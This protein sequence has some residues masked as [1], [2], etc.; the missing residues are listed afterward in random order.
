MRFVARLLG[1]LWALPNSFVAMILCAAASPWGIHARI[2]TGVL[3]VHGRGI[4][5]ALKAVPITGGAIAITLG[6]VVF[7]ASAAALEV[8]R[9]HERVHVRQYSRWGPFFLPAYAIASVIAWIRGRSPY[10]DNAFE[11]SAYAAVAG[12][13]RRLD[14]ARFS[15]ADECSPYRQVLGDSFAALQAN[16]RRA[17]EAPLRAQGVLDVE[18]GTHPFTALLV[19]LLRL[20]AAGRGVP[21]TLRAALESG[22]SAALIASPPTMRWVRRFGG[23]PLVTHQYAHRGRLV[24]R[25]GPGRVH[26][27][28]CVDGDSLVYEQESM[29]FL[30]VPAPRFLAPRIRARVSPEPDGWRVDVVVEW[31]GHLICRYGGIVKPMESTA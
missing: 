8:S 19:A 24:E 29:R 22:K 26:Y 21:V 23:W 16:V 17:H 12:I 31:R 28:L 5:R 20:P 9:A 11:V 30:V 2:V 15:G 7:G 18:H 4:A 13:E 1:Y 3:E 10:R 6:H 25:Y 27:R 14:A